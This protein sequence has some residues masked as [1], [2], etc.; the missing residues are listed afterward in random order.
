MFTPNIYPTP[1]VIPMAIVPQN[2]IL[3]TALNT[4][5]PPVLAAS[6]PK[7]IRNNMADAYK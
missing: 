3:M 1:A 2:T 7:I 5:E 4:L 6:A